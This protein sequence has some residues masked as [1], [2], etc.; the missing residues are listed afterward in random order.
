MMGSQV[1]NIVPFAALFFCAVVFMRSCPILLPAACV[2]WILGGPLASVL[3]GYSAWHPATLVTLAAMLLAALLGYAFRGKKNTLVLLLGGMLSA[4]IFYLVTN[5]A[6]F[7]MDP[8]YAKSKEGLV[9]AMWTGSKLSEI[10]TWVFFRNSL[11]SNALFTLMFV[12]ALKIPRF[13]LAKRFGL[14]PLQETN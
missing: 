4:T 14:A 12:S 5:F 3:Q 2:A 9:Q 10:P 1:P 13:S 8:I 11:V 6:S 7:L